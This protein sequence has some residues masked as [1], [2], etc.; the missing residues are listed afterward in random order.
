MYDYL[1][2]CYISNCHYSKLLNSCLV[3][4]NVAL[5]RKWLITIIQRANPVFILYF[6]WRNQHTDT[7]LS[8]QTTF[9]GHI[10]PFKLRRILQRWNI[11]HILR[12]ETNLS[13]IQIM[14]TYP[15]SALSHRVNVPFHARCAGVCQA[16]GYL[17]LCDSDNFTKQQSRQTRS[18]LYSNVKVMAL[19]VTHV[20]M[21]T[22]LCW[23]NKIY[24]KF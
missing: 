10:I 6:E 15:P 18:Y 19:T 8:N 16:S 1:S 22:E 7:R 4:F 3:S 11:S 9:F 2:I 23:D 13:M 21:F 5:S 24:V 17:S 12:K 14:M 20:F